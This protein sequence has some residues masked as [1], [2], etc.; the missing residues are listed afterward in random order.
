MIWRTNGKE[1]INLDIGAESAEIIDIYGNSHTQKTENSVLHL[2]V[3]E[4]PQYIV[5]NFSK[6]DEV[7]N[8]GF[9][10]S[11]TNIAYG[12]TKTSR[13]NITSLNKRKR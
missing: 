9:E 4:N 6:C 5:G 2:C 7:R 11:E 10:T 3:D 12:I 1:S 8:G 13:I